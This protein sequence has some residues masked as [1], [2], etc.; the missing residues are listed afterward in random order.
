MQAAPE[1]NQ[2]DKRFNARRDLIIKQA[3]NVFGRKGFHATTL[4]DI[5]GQL[6]VTKASLY[7]YFST[8]E[9][10]LFAVLQTSMQEH[11]DRV[12]GALEANAEASPARKLE[13]AITEHLRLLAD[14]YEGAFLLQQEYEL[15]DEEQQSEILTMRADYEQRFSDIIHEGVQS[16]TFRVRDERIAVLMILGSINWFLRWYRSDG[17]FSVDEIARVFVDMIMHGLLAGG[18]ALPPDS[19]S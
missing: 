7:Y 16:H 15:Q 4:D 10:L 17:R 1:P 2:K 5:A 12:D 8:K 9:D 3:A 19:G 13:A 6:G 18:R 11:L 14:Q